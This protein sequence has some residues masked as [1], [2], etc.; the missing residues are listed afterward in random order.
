MPISNL[1]LLSRVSRF[2]QI[3]CITWYRKYRECFT[4]WTF[5]YYACEQEWINN[6]IG[7]FVSDRI[8]TDNSARFLDNGQAVVLW[9]GKTIPVDPDLHRLPVYAP[10]IEE[11][12]ITFYGCRKVSVSSTVTVTKL[13]LCMVVKFGRANVAV[14]DGKLVVVCS[15]FVYIYKNNEVETKI[16]IP[17]KVHKFIKSNYRITSSTSAF[18]IYRIIDDFDDIEVH[19]IGNNI[20]IVFHTE[21]EQKY[22]PLVYT[23]GVDNLLVEIQCLGKQPDLRRLNLQRSVMSDNR[24]FFPSELP[25]ALDFLACT[26][27]FVHFLTFSS[28]FG[29][30][31][32]IWNRVM[33]PGPLLFDGKCHCYI[34]SNIFVAQT[35]GQGY[36]RLER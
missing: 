22:S 15:D 25:S 9:K 23:M 20:I 11:N 19:P 35:K 16:K 24:L 32:A 29:K 2:Y 7:S 12:A 17:D 3:A 36:W 34:D 21:K 30:P 5:S 1:F 26:L 4:S 10:V 14:R 6:L 8:V 28:L 13:P 18:E 33:F 27:R 31:Y